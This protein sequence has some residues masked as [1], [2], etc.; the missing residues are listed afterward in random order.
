MFVQ[1]I[2]P[3]HYLQGP[4]GRRIWSEE[5]GKMAWELAY[6]ELERA[7]ATVGARGTL[8][9]VFGLQGAGK[10]TWIER[11]RAECGPLAVFF[12]AALPSRRHRTRALALAAASATPAV[13]VWINV[14]IE[15]ALERNVLRFGDERIEEATIRHVLSLLEPPSTEEGFR[16]IIEVTR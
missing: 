16:E 13:A 1:H 8:Y 9:I 11:N 3:D 14:P 7:L 6:A 15:T 12:D 10:S 2:D 4:D 5:R